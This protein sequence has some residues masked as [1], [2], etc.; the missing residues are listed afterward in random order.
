MVD[1]LRPFSYNYENFTP[2]GQDL[3]A[4]VSAYVKTDKKKT[5]KSFLRYSD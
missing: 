3:V 5:Y 4:A 2:Y 1:L